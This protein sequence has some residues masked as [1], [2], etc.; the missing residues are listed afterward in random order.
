MAPH[1]LIK[2]KHVTIYPRGTVGGIL[3]MAVINY[4][5]YC[6]L[7]HILLVRMARRYVSQNIGVFINKFIT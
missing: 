6:G 7:D 3:Q 4:L 5:V 2:T 1:Q